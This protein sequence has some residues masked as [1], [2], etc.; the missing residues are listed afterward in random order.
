MRPLLLLISLSF[1]VAAQDWPHYGN[2]PGG[3]RYSPLQQIHVSNVQNLRL[4]WIFH[5]SDFGVTECTPIVVDG[6]MFV[7][8]AGLRVFAL[9]AAT[10][11]QLWV[12]DPYPDSSPPSAAVNRGVAFWSD[13]TPRGQRR[14]V[15]GTWDGRLI[16]LDARTGKPD[17]NFGAG[18]V[19]NLRQG[20][21]R[22]ISGL[23]YGVTS[24]PAIFEDLLIVGFL[25]TE[26][27]TEAAPGD[28][29]AFN[30]RTGA[31]V[32]RFHTVPRRGEFGNN[33]W[34]GTSWL[35]RGGANAW[36]GLSVDPASA[37]VFAG[38]GT[39][40]MD[41]YGGDR[42]G[43]NLFANT[44]LAL[45][46]RTGVRRWHFQV[47]RHDL[48]DYDMPTFPLVVN[49]PA[50]SEV[51]KAVAQ[52]T[53][54]GFVYLLD[55]ATGQ[56]LFPLQERSVP[57]SD[58][59]GEAAWPTQQVPLRPPP[60]AKQGFSPDDVTDISP[61]AHAYVLAQ[62]Q[63]YRLGPLFTPPS[64]QGS[65]M[66]PGNLGGANWS[67]GSYDPETGMLYV[68]SNNFP[69]IIQLTPSEP[70]SLFPFSYTIEDL[71]DQEGYP[72]GK[73]PWG[74]LSAI[75]L[76]TGTIRW[77]STLGEFPELTARG[78]APTGTPNL[79]GSIVTAGGLLFIGATKDEKFRAFHKSTGQLLWQ[80]SLPAA[81]HATPATY[82]ANGKQYV[83]IAAGG[84]RLNTRPG[85][86][87]VAFAL[88]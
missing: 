74:Q 3:T 44:V 82:M 81:A 45:N 9:N 26:F 75:N 32:W 76:R 52:V 40:V 39:P 31:E 16:S 50:A 64:L 66:M 68:N 87:F 18:G 25:N 20:F 1:T 38:T 79:G 23:L 47:I 12:Y 84:A 57:A 5:T 58:V 7:I 71:T 13:G 35:N 69:K 72:G 30:V 60:F 29:R 33:T 10:G 48:W 73:P 19:V 77:Q 65:I 70:G 80:F 46:A 36:A 37:T 17:P 51:R 42:K 67:G 83:V 49:I 27:P 61:E 15:F 56:T 21:G 88:P 54:T 55:R 8:S 24:P 86:A 2:D 6:V 59:P 41:F 22:D 11:Q 53:K 34:E 4:A 62:V 63:N 28:I 14:V 85:D 78:I 43:E